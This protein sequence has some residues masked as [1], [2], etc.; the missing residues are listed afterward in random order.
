MERDW[1]I[2]CN[3]KGWTNNDHGVQWLQRCFEPHT[4]ENANGGST[5]YM[6]KN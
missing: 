5:P 6:A 1:K 2:S 3:S 4:C